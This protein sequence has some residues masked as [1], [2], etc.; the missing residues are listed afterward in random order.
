LILRLLLKETNIVSCVV[1][2]SVAM[3]CCVF[4]F[5]SNHSPKVEATAQTYIGDITGLCGYIGLKNC[6]K[7][8]QIFRLKQICRALLL[9]EIWIR[10]ESNLLERNC[11]CNTKRKGHLEIVFASEQTVGDVAKFRSEASKPY[12]T[13]PNYARKWQ[14]A[15]DITQISE[16]TIKDI[17]QLHSKVSKTVRNIAELRS[18]VTEPQGTSNVSKP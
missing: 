5:C 14:N 4:T 6:F 16:Q 8:K 2:Q 1:V 10:V 7:L 17:S 13:S 3:R 15:R 11:P 9:R 12:W 18:K